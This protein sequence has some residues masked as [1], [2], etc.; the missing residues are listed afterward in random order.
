LREKG[1]VLGEGSI[2]QLFGSPFHRFGRRIGGIMRQGAARVDMKH[3]S[4]C[5]IRYGARPRRV[6]ASENDDENEAVVACESA[7]RTNHPLGLLSGCEKHPKQ[8][9]DLEEQ[10]ELPAQNR[11]DNARRHTKRL[12]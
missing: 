4:S 9:L 6:L 2:T 3:V 12:E 8:T 11:A 1:E 7:S 5:R 10:L